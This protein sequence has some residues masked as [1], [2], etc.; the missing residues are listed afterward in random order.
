MIKESAIIGLGLLSAYGLKQ[1]LE[2]FLGHN[3]KQVNLALKAFQQKFP[4]LDRNDK[5]ARTY[6]LLYQKLSI[7][8]QQTSEG[9]KKENLHGLE[10]FQKEA[11]QFCLD[12]SRYLSKDIG[13]KTLQ[14]IELIA[15]KIIKQ[16]YTTTLIPVKK[17]EY[18]HSTLK[19]CHGQLL[20]LKFL[21]HKELNEIE[22]K[23]RKQIS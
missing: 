18:Y 8:Y 23:A 22:L 17:L 10:A 4:H 3:K 13:E 11:R 19:K 14:I 2:N 6:A 1:F 20:E 5:N 15:E 16:F 9:I 7:L 21:I 12:H